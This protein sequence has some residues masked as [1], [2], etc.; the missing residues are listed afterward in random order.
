MNDYDVELS[1]YIK[2]DLLSKH[3]RT[4]KKYFLIYH[5]FSQFTKYGI[6][7]FQL[8]MSR[9]SKEIN[10]YRTTCFLSNQ[11]G[12]EKYFETWRQSGA[13]P[14]YRECWCTEN[15]KIHMETII[16]HSSQLKTQSNFNWGKGMN[17]QSFTIVLCNIHVHI[18]WVYQFMQK[19][20]FSIFF[21]VCSL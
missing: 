17:S 13:T 20:A 8:I 19:L 4:F 10:L 6:P 16:K 21:L 18:L 3:V 14:A 15:I 7:K 9:K 5:C 12:Q 1:A 11:I 2:C